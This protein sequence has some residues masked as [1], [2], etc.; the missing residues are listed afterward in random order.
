MLT[1]D[2]FWL[3]RL[4]KM[5]DA[6]CL[7]KRLAMWKGYLATSSE[8]GEVIR[9]FVI[10][11]RCLCRRLICQRS[12]FA[13]CSIFKCTTV[14]YLLSKPSF[15]KQNQ[16]IFLDLAGNFVYKQHTNQ[17]RSS[18]DTCWQYYKHYNQNTVD[19]DRF[20]YSVDV[21]HLLSKA[22]LFTSI[23]NKW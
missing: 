21:L 16:C 3:P 5:C 19:Y 11:F 17:Q 1:R 10:N 18:A 6:H 15:K 12:T 4:K 7:K 2:L 23:A 9:Y 13:G 8:R 20:Y 22:D 14:L